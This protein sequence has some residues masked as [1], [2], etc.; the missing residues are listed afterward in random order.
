MN[1][2]I[3]SGCEILGEELPLLLH[4]KEDIYLLSD[5]VG[6]FGYSNRPLSYHTLTPFTLAILQENEPVIEWLVTNVFD[7]RILLDPL[8]EFKIPEGSYNAIQ[9]AIQSRKN[10]E[11]KQLQLLLFDLL[12]SLFPELGQIVSDYTQSLPLFETGQKD[13]VASCGIFEADLGSLTSWSEI[14]MKNGVFD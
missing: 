13:L 4:V 1:G 6:H 2:Q 5:G 8:A 7:Q 12:Y 9:R 10:Q 14:N 11:E 3:S